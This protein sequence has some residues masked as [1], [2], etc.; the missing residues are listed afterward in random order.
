MSVLLKLTIYREAYIQTNDKIETSKF[1]PFLD[2][3]KE[4]RFCPSFLTSYIQIHI[5]SSLI[6][7]LK[8]GRL[9]P[10]LYTK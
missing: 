10:F 7:F 4:G 5:I 6:G 2:I 3:Q 8:L 9:I 1:M